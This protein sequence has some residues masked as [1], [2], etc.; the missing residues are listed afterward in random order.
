MRSVDGNNDAEGVR[1][2]GL[3][4]GEEELQCGGCLRWLHPQMELTE[5]SH[6]G[7]ELLVQAWSFPRTVLEKGL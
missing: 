5:P 7:T 2:V 4:R 3:G 1:E 6:V